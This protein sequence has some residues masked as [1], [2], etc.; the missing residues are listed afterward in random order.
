[1]HKFY[2]GKVDLS[3]AIAYNIA[4]LWNS[5]KEGGLMNL[6]KLVEFRNRSNPFCQRLGIRVEEIQQGYARSVMTVSPED[7]NPLGI[8]H[9]GVYF[10]LADTTCGS[11]AAS[12]GFKAVT[13]DASYHFLRS[14]AVGDTLI[15]EAR[16]LK[17]GRTVCVYELRITG[18]Q[19]TLLGYGTFSFYLT[20]EPLEL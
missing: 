12:H 17:A 4:I 10:S 19:G 1:M 18:P 5:A 7:T 13:M 15:A 14:A 20:G 8:P 6:K 16:E 2:R 9:G 3:P 11:A